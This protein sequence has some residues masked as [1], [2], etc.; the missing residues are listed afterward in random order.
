M[1]VNR[2][3]LGH[4]E[5]P[6][7]ILCKASEEMIGVL[8]CTVK[9]WEHKF[10][11][12]DTLTFE[13]PYMTDG[14]PTPFYD[15]IDIMKYV[16]VPTI[17]R[18]SI[19]DVSIKNEGETSEL[20]TVNCQDYS[21]QIGQKY[22]VDFVINYG[23]TS[24]IDGVSFYNPGNQAYSLLDLVLEKL[25][26]W[27][28]G[29][30]SN[31][32]RTMKRSFEV[33]RQDVYTFLVQDVAKAFECI[34]VFDSLNKTINA[35]T[36][37]EYG[38]DTNISVSYSNLLQ[39]ADL[40]L[41]LD[42][43]KTAL[44]LQGSD[45]LDVREVNM[46]YDTIYS[47][48][49]FATEEYF[50]TSLLSAYN[51]WKSL[52]DTTV[53]LD[54]FTYKT[55]VISRA[56]L[57][58]K[59]YKD[60]YTYLL[61]KYQNYYTEISKW[62]STMIPYGFTRRYIGYGTF[63]ATEDGSDARTF[64]RQTSTV[65]V[66]SL[67]TYGD[68]NTLYL[69]ENSYDMYRYD[70][71]WYNVNAWDNVCLA[72]LKEKLA[73]AENAQAVAMKA[74]YGD[75]ESARYLST[76]LPAVYTIKAIEAKVKT[77]ND[78]LSSLSS[79]QAI[80]QTDKS[81]IVNKT[82]MVNNFTVEQLKELSTFIREETLSTENYV[83]TDIMT[84]DERFEM[85]YAFLE[86]GQKELAKVSMPQLQ[87]SCSLLNLYAIPEFDGYSGDFDI[88]NYVWVTLRDDYTIKAKL[89]GITIDFLDHSQFTVTF[90]NVARKA[91]NIFTDV[92]DALNAAT[93]AATSVSFNQSYWSA[94]AQETDTIGKA[95]SDGLLSQSYYLS[96]AEDNETL[97]DENGIWITTTTGP[98]GRENTSEYD[99]IYVGGGRILFTDDGW[100]TVSMSVGRGDVSY[101]I[102]QN[103]T[104]S[105]VTRSM[106]GTYA[107]F[108]I[109]GYVGGSMIVGGDIYSSNYQT[110]SS[111]SSGNKGAHINLTDG[112]FEFNSRSSG[113]KR[114]VLSN[115]TLTMY[116]TIQASSGHIG[117]DDNGDG[118][119]VI[120][121]SKLYNDKST[122]TDNAEGV[123]IGTDAIALGHAAQ[124]ETTT[125]YVTKSR[126]Q[127]DKDGHLY[128][129]AANI[130]GAIT[131]TSGV[132]GGFTIT[133]SSIYNRKDSLNS[134]SINGVYIGTDGIALGSDP[135]FKVTSSGYLTA[136]YGEI[137]GATI[138]SNSITSS[139]GNWEIHSNG[140]AYFSDVTITGVNGGS[141]FGGVSYD[142]R[143]RTY[144]DSNSSYPFTGNCVNHIESISANYIEANYLTAMRADI[145]DLWADHVS[146]NDLDAINADIG[147]LNVE[148]ANIGD[149]VADKADISE[150]NAI[151]I[152]VRD[153]EADYITA[154]YI[155]SD[156]IVGKLEGEDC[157]IAGL[158]VHNWFRLGSYLARWDSKTISGVTIEF[159]SHY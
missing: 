158:E 7:F 138:S 28:I 110:N 40:T 103:N 114:L 88:G 147:N 39:N 27:Q 20:K 87:F 45:D 151:E 22:L 133:S 31:S 146:V 127:V 2:N 32:L 26:E 90:G 89:L 123:Y 77:V 29:H 148:V 55:G 44:T 37:S 104:V 21:C 152:R 115:D 43:I 129:A 144:Y 82:A 117:C 36:E 149:L 70:G 112:T 50:S 141:E 60:A 42:E 30:I 78:T 156:L 85:L 95:L 106:F 61:A 34:F 102:I 124:Y 126:F 139:N 122:A 79:D 15:D 1:I 65:K 59:S 131:A 80:I 8:R 81:V 86:F 63:S 97:I 72:S 157:N 25:P 121:S 62:Q 19:K 128:A 71:S 47:F 49:F 135:G 14:E 98:Y 75:P 69:M 100:R 35:Y 94:A 116:G 3:T 64:E 134:D 107:D 68:G 67:P 108:I 57:Q 53:N 17:G 84:E 130:S 109:A 58:G 38:Q 16:L 137:G 73:S 10:Q 66:S 143:G 150:L 6:D 13:V 120:E 118:G 24:S 4:L 91:R 96:N 23:T 74:D 142:G 48:D 51:A 119:F 113:K 155:S 9:K 92:T 101:P 153:I 140:H 132:I 145:E 41:S 18:F 83:V 54:L 76:Y 111:V 105:F 136:K 5:E 11:D 154:S 46:G 56:E 159:L 99:G 93:A 125:G 52:L 33:S 12:L